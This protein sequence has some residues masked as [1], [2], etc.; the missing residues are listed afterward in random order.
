MQTPLEQLSVELDGK[1][2]LVSE[3]EKLVV[4]SA[5]LMELSV[6]I[7]KSKDYDR[8][9]EVLSVAGFLLELANEKMAKDN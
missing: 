4:A 3:I 1:L 5:T 2:E 6:E 7:G 9:M 8:L